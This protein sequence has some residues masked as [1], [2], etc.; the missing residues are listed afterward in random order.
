MAATGTVPNALIRVFLGIA[1][2]R[3][4]GGVSPPRDDCLLIHVKRQDKRVKGGTPLK[5]PLCAQR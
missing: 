3:M 1:P 5:T 4:P 2:G